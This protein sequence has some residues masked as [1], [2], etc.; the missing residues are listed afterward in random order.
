M[1]LAQ[2]IMI[3]LL[4][5]FLCHLLPRS[6]PYLLLSCIWL[7]ICQHFLIKWKK[8]PQTNSF[9]I[10]S[11][12]K[13]VMYPYDLLSPWQQFIPSNTPK[14]S[15]TMQ[16]N[17]PHGTSEIKPKPPSPPTIPYTSNSRSPFSS[18]PP[19]ESKWTLTALVGRKCHS[20]HSVSKPTHDHTGRLRG[21]SLSL[22]DHCFTYSLEQHWLTDLGACEKWVGCPS[23]VASENHVRVQGDKDVPLTPWQDSVGQAI[24]AGALKMP[25]PGLSSPLHSSR[26]NSCH[27]HTSSYF[28]SWRTWIRVWNQLCKLKGTALLKS[29]L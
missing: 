2:E 4:S 6:F 8:P 11:S 15:S 10:D 26:Q 22:L 18:P 29:D 23:P 1:W 7:P 13:K 17:S 3:R 28:I 9:W 19:H 12:A 20:N 16:L 27:R 25:S 24:C 21:C 14:C 5:A